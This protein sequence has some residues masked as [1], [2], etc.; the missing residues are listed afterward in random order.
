MAANGSRVKSA[1]GAGPPKKLVIQAF[2]SKPT[3]PPGFEA[4]TWS[5]LQ[6]CVHA[7][8][9]K[10]PVSCSLEELYSAVQDMCMHKLAQGLYVKLQHECDVHIANQLLN[11]K[12]CLQLEP[13]AFLEK[14]NN[15]W[16]DYCNQMLT[17]RQVFLYLDRT[18]VITTAG[19]RS[20]FDMGLQLFRKHLLDHPEVAD[21]TIQGLLFLVQRD[22]VAEIVNRMLLKS[23]LKM[24][25]NLGLYGDHFQQPFL[26]QTQ[27]FYQEE[28][29][30][31]MQELSVP[32]YLLRCEIRLGEEFERCQTYL[33]SS[34][35]KPLIQV[36]EKQLISRHI[37]LIL[38][39]GFNSLLDSHRVEDLARLYVLAARIAAFD[40]LKNAFKDYIKA[41]G[42]KIVQDEEKDKDMVERLLDF[43]AKLDEVVDRA[44]QRQEQFLYALK[45]AFE[46][47]INQ[48]QNKPAELI[49]K[50]IDGKLRAGNKGQTEEELERMLDKALMLFR[51]IQGKDVFEAFYKKDL[52]KRLLLG[53][54]ASIDAEKAMIS[55]LKSECGSQFTNKLEGM[56][57]DV[58]LSRD[59]M[60]SFKQSAAIRDNLPPGIDMNVSVLTSGYWPS[61]PLMEAKL[62]Q[63]LALYQEVFKDFYLKKHSGRRL[64]WYNT[65]GTCVLKACFPKGQKELSVSL[66][67]A[68]V[69][70]LFNDVDE[71]KFS[72]VRE[73]AGIEDK[74]LRRTLQSLACGKVRVLTKEPK[75]KEVGDEDVFR[76]N[77]D[78][79]ERLFRIKINSIQMKET[80]EENKKTNDAVIQDRQYQIDAAIVRIMKTRKTLSHKLL[81]DEVWQQLKFPLKAADLKRRIESLI[82]REYL[83]RDSK[84][85]NVYNY[86]A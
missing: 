49:A 84:D 78:F 53:K 2:Q 38:E 72:E 82:D 28:G 33:D 43:N 52:A 41:T 10:R 57:K 8:H 76:Y 25:N 83:A 20:L 24:F 14:I 51:Y 13:I 62:P 32:A 34:T 70:T 65:L 75:S 18:Y 19:V 86:L 55:K 66:F 36:V 63:E 64:A 73:M 50:F 7:V 81:V 31:L 80:E 4:D 12:S 22:R 56:F 9:G 40:A 71:F 85:T 35:R 74:E 6:D 42:L 60:T 39:K 79:T 61:Y 23:L 15:V 26:D 16:E 47:F 21:K 46:H 3:L 17:I 48:R 67:Q 77:K 11:L 69:L 58:E 27:Q 1:G 45:D 68:V 59:I 29:D 30:K 5:K 54:S 44:F 37:A